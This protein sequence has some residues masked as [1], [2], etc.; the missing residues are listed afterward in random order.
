[1]AKPDPRFFSQ[2]VE[3]AGAGPCRALAVGDHFDNDYAPAKA[4]GLHA[5]LIDRGGAVTDPDVLRVGALTELTA[6]IEAP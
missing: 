6:L 5:V 3:R 2:A 4:A 1:M